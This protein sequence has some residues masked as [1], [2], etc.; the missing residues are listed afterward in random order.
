MTN[1][2]RISIVQADIEW[3]DTTKNLENYAALLAGLKGKSDLAVLPEMFSTGFSMQ[4][5]HLAETNNGHT[6]KTLQH[7]SQ[8]LNLAIAGSF[9]AKNDDEK[10]YNR[11]FFITPSGE[12]FFADKR[13]LFRLGGEDK[14]FTAGSDN[15]LI[16]Y[17][18]WN[19]RL[20]ICYD[21][22]FPVWI[23]NRNNEYDLLL[24]VANWPRARA[25]VWKT[26]LQARAIENQCYVC[27]V[28]RVGQHGK[29]IDYQG[30]SILIDYK[31]IP[32]AEAQTDQSDLQTHTINREL[33]QTFRQK[34]PVWQDSDRFEII[35]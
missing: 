6:I 28:N 11:G 33:L 4:A 8:E 24:C 20:I 35:F 15:S 2:L 27:G 21:L 14:V 25:N 3:E 18:N 17:R 34:F 30:D 29:I 5:Q 13:H 12:T 10:L 19:I 22:R 16:P 9:L 32:I 26:L 31:G 1:D 23:R 7:F